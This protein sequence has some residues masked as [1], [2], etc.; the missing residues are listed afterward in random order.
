MVLTEQPSI[1]LICLGLILLSSRTVKTSSIPLNFI[2]T[3][4]PV[5]D[6]IPYLIGKVKDKQMQYV[7]PSGDSASG[8]R[9]AAVQYIAALLTAST[10]IRIVPRVLSG[11]NDIMSHFKTDEYNS[12]RFKIVDQVSY[13]DITPD[14]NKV[15]LIHTL[16]TDMLHH[17]LSTG[18]HNIGL[19][20]TETTSIPRWLAAQMNSNIDAIVVPTEWNRQ[21]FIDSGVNIDIHVVP[22]TRS[23]EWAFMYSASGNSRKEN[24]PY[25]FYFLGAWNFR[26]NPEGALRA[27]LRA[28]PDTN[29]HNQRIIFKIS[30]T[31]SLIP[32][33]KAVMEDEGVGFSSRLGR[34][35]HVITDRV[36]DEDI[37][38]IHYNSHCFVSLHRGEGWGIGL[39]D[40]VLAGNQCI[41]T[42]YS[43]PN[44]YL[45]PLQDKFSTVGFNYQDVKVDGS[46]LYFTEANGKMT[47]WADP[48]IDDAVD[49][50]RMMVRNRLKGLSGTKEHD[51]F[52]HAYSWET[53]GSKLESVIKKYQELP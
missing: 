8:Y 20:V 4:F 40:A 29:E 19:T 42:R 11:S 22:H 45:S 34:D 32:Y 49:S 24:A 6:T 44:E 12:L 27:Y 53:V 52:V 51:D 41:Y 10:D 50:M 38:R 5:Y 39:F 30:N 3:F 2:L 21:V 28:F 23:K 18:H 16:P 15:A 26:K 35:V 36:S 37:Y 13:T 48:I 1:L 17:L 43:A 25:T 14:T 31:M 33:V 47:Q 7:L 46:A 9:Q